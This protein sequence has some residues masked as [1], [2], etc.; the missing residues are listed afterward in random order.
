MTMRRQ[1]IFGMTIGLLC[2]YWA[3]RGINVHQVATALKQAQGQWIAIAML[4]YGVGYILRSIRWKVLLTPIQP[5]NITTLLPILMIGFMANNLLPFRMGELIRA[6]FCGR[7]LQI[8]R[9]AS[10]GSIF[11]ERITD[12]ISFLLVFALAV[13]FFPFP[14]RIRSAAMG[15]GVLMAVLIIGLL[16]ASR[17]HA[18]WKHQATRLPIPDHWKERF[19]HLFDKFILGLSGL[20]HAPTISLAMFISLLIWTVEGSFIFLIVHAFPVSISYLQAFVVLFF[21]GLSVALPQAPGYVGTM[22]LFGTTA[23]SLLGV[24]KDLG[25]SIILTIHAFQF[26]FILALGLWSLAHEGLTLSSLVTSTER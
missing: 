11:I 9:V 22:E 20:N 4:L 19:L 6:H 21:L 12:S 14:P 13:M 7:K 1:M 16:L 2:L 24:P 23:L 5:T 18:F 3:F 26:A 15:M 10:L 17:F 8:S 25:L